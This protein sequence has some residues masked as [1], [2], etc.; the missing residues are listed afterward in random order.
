[1]SLEFAQPRMAQLAS[2]LVAH[3][4]PRPLVLHARAD[5]GGRATLD[6]YLAVV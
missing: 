3:R 1:V 5:G 6:P 2:A 4:L